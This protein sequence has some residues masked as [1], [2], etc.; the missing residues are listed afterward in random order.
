MSEDTGGI[1]LFW[2]GSVG[3]N[4]ATLH[5]RLLGDVFPHRPIFISHDIRGG[6][7]WYARIRAEI[8]QMDAGLFFLAPDSLESAWLAHEC[9][10]VTASKGLSSV[11][12]VLVGISQDLANTRLD[13]FRQTQTRTFGTMTEFRSL[14]ETCADILKDG[15][16]SREIADAAA[17]AWSGGKDEIST[18]EAQVSSCVPNPYRGVVKYSRI[19][20]SKF[21]IPEV[22]D[23]C[24]SEIFL[25]GPNHFYILNLQG[26]PT[27]FAALL[28]WLVGSETRRV[29]F[30]LS[31]VWNP[32]VF[33]CYRLFLPAG[34]ADDEL[35]A[36]TQ[37]LRQPGGPHDIETIMRRTLS[38]R[39]F[40]R[41][42][43]TKALQI[44]LLTT[45]LD[46]MWFI[47][48]GTGHGRCQVA[49]FNTM[50]PQERPFFHSSEVKG[51]ADDIFEHYH[52]LAD[53]GFHYATPL[54]PRR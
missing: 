8:E 22:L 49:L 33:S 38:D 2:S 1:G 40:E 44:S 50:A 10:L 52:S 34:A 13:I 21:N 48:A 30:L 32:A 9:G 25:V 54:W 6:E 7:Q 14:C 51:D 3:A 43:E 39:Q 15:R 53:H 31:D 29:R 4:A 19:G 28:K 45:I 16:S 11:V 12:P 36:M 24:Q 17:A 37:S 23:R 42:V 18:L 5:A 46:N 41:V 26:N 27:R 35:A 20:E 47:D